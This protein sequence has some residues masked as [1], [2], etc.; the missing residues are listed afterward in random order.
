MLTIKKRLPENRGAGFGMGESTLFDAI[1]GESVLFEAEDMAEDA[2]LTHGA[3]G[4]AC[5]LDALTVALGAC[6]AVVMI[7]V[8]SPHVISL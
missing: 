7:G 5:L 1:Q 6:H 8:T 3:G 4:F 2:V